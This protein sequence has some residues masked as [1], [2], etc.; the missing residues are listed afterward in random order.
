MKNFLFTTL[1]S[2]STLITFSQSRF[3]IDITQDLTSSHLK[4]SEFKTEKIGFNRGAST[5]GIS[6]NYN[7]FD[8]FYFEP[9][10]NATFLNDSSK[11]ISQR[12]QENV[13]ADVLD[14]PYTENILLNQYSTGTRVGTK[15]YSFGF[16]L[17]NKINN[18]LYIGGGVHFTYLKTV[19]ND[20]FFT[21]SYYYNGNE[22]L[23][24]VRSKMPI[25][26]VFNKM[27]ISIPIIIRAYVPIKE[28][29]LRFS[30][31]GHLSVN[32]RLEASFGFCFK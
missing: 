13:N 22:Y 19:I 28:T 29:A 7:A 32:P 27:S 6:Y 12:F 26:Y 15:H 1:L 30:V 18:F 21:E 4:Y 23:L 11:I 3:C 8:D 31:L 25:P 10:M 5:I 17:M 14:V 9:F 16:N 20:D 2:F 24:A